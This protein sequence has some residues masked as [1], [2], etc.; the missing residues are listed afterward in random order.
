MHFNT[1][2]DDISHILKKKN[3]FKLTL[4]QLSLTKSYCE[5]KSTGNF[6]NKV[7]FS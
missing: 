7:N 3:N 6:R 2:P 5:V 4:P 1:A